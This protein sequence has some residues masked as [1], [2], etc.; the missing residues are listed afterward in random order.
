[1]E[2]QVN[3]PAHYQ[4]DGKECIDVMIEKFGVQ[5]VIDF[6]ICNDFKYKWRAGKKNGNTSEQ[7]LAKAAWYRNKAKE[8]E[9]D[10]NRNAGSTEEA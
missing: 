9:D 5:A 3:H 7:D 1:M 8:L 10:H 6:C 4:K 2:E